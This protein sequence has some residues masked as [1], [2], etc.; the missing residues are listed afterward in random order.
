M[1]QQSQVIITYARR[2]MARARCYLTPGK[3]RVFVN[4]IP[5]E[6]IPMEV[7]RMKIMEPLLLAGEKISSSID[8]KI[9]VEGGGVMG[10]ADAARMA[11]ARALVKFTGSK[12]LE[13]I[14][15]VYDRTMLAGD[16]RQTES[17]KWMRY[18]AR[19]W[20]QKAYR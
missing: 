1:S 15:K 20:R 3:G 2:K 18:S 12:E 16:P 6:I 13:E 17:E 19:R 8:A 14:Y 11:L 4:D 5:L 7:V 10:Q 9:Y